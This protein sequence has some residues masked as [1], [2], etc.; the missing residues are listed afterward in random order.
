MLQF[1]DNGSITSVQGFKA[2]GINCGLKRQKKDLALIY[3]D[4]PCE[5]AGTFT[6]N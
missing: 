6:L 2:A 3:S 4:V 5:A 1:I